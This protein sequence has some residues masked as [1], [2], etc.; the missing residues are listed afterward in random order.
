MDRSPGGTS[1]PVEVRIRMTVWQRVTPFLPTVVMTAAL[2][3][4]S[5]AEMSPPGGLTGLVTFWIVLL[6]LA[7]V[8]P[9]YFG[10]TLTPS[11]AVVRNV[12]RRTIPWADIQAVRTESVLGVRSVVLYEA[13]GRRTHLRAPTTGY[14]AWDRRFEE[15]FHTIGTWWQ[16]HRGPDWTPIPPPPAWWN[17]PTGTSSSTARP[18]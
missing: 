1:A 17:T 11:A 4:T 3:T 5:R 10:V 6:A 14:L 8:L 9:A 15:K 16:T 12:R 13:D 7:A 18:T 2:F